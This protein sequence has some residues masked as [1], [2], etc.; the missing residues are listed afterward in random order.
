MLSDLWCV[1][2]GTDLWCVVCM[3][4]WN[5]LCYCEL[6][7]A[8]NITEN[9]M[10]IHGLGLYVLGGRKRQCPAARFLILLPKIRG[11]Y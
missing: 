10:L 1:N 9:G 11:I 3:S 7:L 6:S 2:S 5:T 4:G 8:M